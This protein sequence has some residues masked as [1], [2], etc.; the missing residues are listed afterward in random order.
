MWYINL[1]DTKESQCVKHYLL[2]LNLL[3]Q[4]TY[5]VKEYEAAT[6]AGI[7]T[8]DPAALQFFAF[9]AE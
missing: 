9:L 4:Q 2:I 3:H 1:P 8:D 6:H 5:A 7:H